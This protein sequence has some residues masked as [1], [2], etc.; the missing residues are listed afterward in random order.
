MIR[1][2]IQLDERQYRRLK[3]LAA[4][5]SKSVARLV[6]E[7]VDQLLAQQDRDEA[8]KRLKGVGGS[9]SD[10]SAEK[11]VSVRHDEHLEG[12]YSK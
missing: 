2:Q 3:A 12:N 8:W 11:D 6:R 4:A 1:T 10:P 9:C 5:Q 7:G